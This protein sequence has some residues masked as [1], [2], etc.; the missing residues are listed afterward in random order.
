MNNT[1]E[2]LEAVLVDMDHTLIQSEPHWCAA[3]RRLMEAHG[4]RWRAS[5]GEALQGTAMAEAIEIMRAKAGFT[6]PTEEAIEILL[7]GVVEA[8][9]AGIIEWMPGART[10]LDSLRQSPLATALVTSA[11]GRFSREIVGL[12][13]PGTFGAVVSGD[14]VTNSKPAP[15]PYLRAAGQLG[16]A[17]SRCLVIEDSLAGLQSGLAAGMGV[18]VVPDI[19]EISPGEGYAVR[20]SL[21]G[22]TVADLRAIHAQL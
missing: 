14:D 18:L 2:P 21:E 13:P 6:L 19:Q 5:D 3:E 7:D 10:L 20:D 4:Y 8:A 9:R 17:P 1:R 15:D 22:L 16:V 12:L 11:F